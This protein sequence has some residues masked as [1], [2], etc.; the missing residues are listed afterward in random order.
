MI[1]HLKGNLIFRSSDFLIIEVAQIGYQVYTTKFTHLNIGDPISLWTYYH[2]GSDNQPRL[3][4]FET[5]EA[6]LLFQE[7]L[8]VQGVGPKIALK[9]VESASPET[10][11]T[12]ILNKDLTFFT[13]IKGLGKKGAQKII[14]ELQNVLVETAPES[15]SS[16]TQSTVRSA[17]ISLGFSTSE[18]QQALNQVDISQLSESAALE[19][20]LQFLGH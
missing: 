20:L 16:S 6:Y 2:V 13:Q 8:K 18:I 12:A 14:L 3:Y 19:K 5:R 11:Q 10:I 15:T 4:G 17:L 9:I 1:A 7:F